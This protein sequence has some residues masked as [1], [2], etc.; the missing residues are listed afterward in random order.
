MPPVALVVDDSMLIRHTVCRLLE[1]HGFEVET[2]TNGLEAVALL[3][4]RLP[5]LIV[6]DLQMPKMT[7]RELITEL[8]RRSETRTIPLVVISGRESGF[9]GG[10]SRADYCI[11]KDIDIQSQLEKALNA[12]RESGAAKTHSARK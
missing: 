11:H 3:D 5:D 7:G 12:M 8:K 9:N 4:S 10:E 6:T 1:E 2:A